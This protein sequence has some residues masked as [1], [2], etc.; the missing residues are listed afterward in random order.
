MARLLSHRNLVGSIRDL[1]RPCWESEIHTRI[2]NE[3]HDLQE[4]GLSLP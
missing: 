4:Q 1:Q 3:V 2:L